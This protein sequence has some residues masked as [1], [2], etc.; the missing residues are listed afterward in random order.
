MSQRRG[1]PPSGYLPAGWK[2]RYPSNGSVYFD[3]TAFNSTPGFKY[4]KLEPQAHNDNNLIAEAEGACGDS[5]R[6]TP[7]N[8]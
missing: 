5:G 4:A 3:I 8:E 1:V 7:A 6:G 2:T